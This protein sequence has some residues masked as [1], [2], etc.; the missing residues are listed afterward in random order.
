MKIYIINDLNI[1]FFF[2]ENFIKKNIFFF[3][4]ILYLNFTSKF[5][6]SL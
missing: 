2:L 5:R 6:K 4:Y 1:P 3:L